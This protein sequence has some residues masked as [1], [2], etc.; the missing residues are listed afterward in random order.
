[1]C[2]GNPLLFCYSELE[3]LL[4]TDPSQ[5][6]GEDA[7]PESIGAGPSHDGFISGPSHSEPAVPRRQRT[8]NRLRSKYCIVMFIFYGTNCKPYIKKQQYSSSTTG[9]VR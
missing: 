7:P 3:V 9:T 1:M 8:H 6:P 4:E 2:Y 5:E